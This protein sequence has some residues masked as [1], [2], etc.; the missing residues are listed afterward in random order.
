MTG[1]AERALQIKLKELDSEG[2]GKL[3]GQAD[4]VEAWIKDLREL[5]FTMLENDKPVAGY[6]LVAKRAMRQWVNDASARTYL[7]RAGVEPLKPSEVISPAQA[8]K[9]LKKVKYTEPGA[10]A[11]VA[12]QPDLVIL[13]TNQK[14]QAEPFR[15]LGL[16]V[17]FNQE[18][19]SLN[20]VLENVRLLG[21]LKYRF[22]YSQNA[23]D[24][25]VEVGFLA[26]I[27]ASELGLDPAV[28]KRSGLLHDIGEITLPSEMLR[29]KGQFGPEEW[30]VMRA[31]PKTVRDNAL[32][33]QAVELM[34]HHRITSVLVVDEH[35]LLCG[36][37]NTHDLMRAKVI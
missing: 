30:A 13:A 25:S 10:E 22:S 5:A 19:D 34:E 4:L 7:E 8:E 35:G 32:A 17:L 28:A 14:A 21:R 15:K 6:K 33:A 27:V 12:L 37:L 24:H 3:L 29:K 26:S 9:A 20:G 16:T 2:I 11:E 18:P 1:A 23:L 31:H 36:A